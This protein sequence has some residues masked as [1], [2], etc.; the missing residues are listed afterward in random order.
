MIDMLELIKLALRI[1]T[2]AFDDELQLYINDC[3]AEMTAL[4]VVGITPD[5][6]ATSSAEESEGSSGEGEGSEGGGDTP[7]MDPQV[8]SA[9]I[10]YCKW[11]FGFNDDA[12]RWEKIYHT[13]L[14]QLK[15]MTGHTEW[16]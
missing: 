6:E 7:E 2:D 1:A 14:A 13:K 12:D 3:C 15:T 10:A 11:K 4:G 5:N 9:L 16:S 8:Q